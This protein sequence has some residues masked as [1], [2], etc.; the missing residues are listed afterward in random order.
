MSA[1]GDE[2]PTVRDRVVRLLMSLYSET[3]TAAGCI[4]D[5]L[6]AEG[7]LRPGVTPPR[8]VD[9]YPVFYCAGCVEGP[10]YTDTDEFFCPSCEQVTTGRFV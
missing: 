7:L 2:V 10:E 8:L 9:G 1:P 5:D 3:H 6:Q 4:A